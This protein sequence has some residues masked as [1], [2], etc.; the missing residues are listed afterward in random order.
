MG[1]GEKQIK[2]H[3]INLSYHIM[4]CRA[5]EYDIQGVMLCKTSLFLRVN[6]LLK[7]LNPYILK[8]YLGDTKRTWLRHYA[9]S[10]KAA[11]MIAPEVT[12]FFS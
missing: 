2:L 4:S 8:L 6:T 10:Q 1:L 3:K 9:K 5:T 12:G 7:T 11:D